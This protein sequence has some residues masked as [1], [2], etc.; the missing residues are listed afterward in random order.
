MITGSR[1]RSLDF[2]NQ[3]AKFHENDVFGNLALKNEVL[4]MSF[5]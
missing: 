2:E 5:A 1:H 3:T 4:Y